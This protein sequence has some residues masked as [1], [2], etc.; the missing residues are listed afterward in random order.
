M[1]KKTINRNAFN[2]KLIHRYYF[3]TFYLDRK[4]RK[5]LVPDFLKK[6]VT[7]LNLIVPEDTIYYKNYRA[8]FTLYFKDDDKGYPV[9]IKWHSKKLNKKNQL[10]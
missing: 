8:D 3:E 10:I 2:E 7:K 9:E 5:E 4:K 1:L 6:K